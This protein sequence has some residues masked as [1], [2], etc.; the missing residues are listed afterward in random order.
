ME[1]FESMPHEQIYQRAQRIDAAAIL[2]SSFAWL[3]VAAGVSSSAPTAQ[4]G[5]AQVIDEAGWSGAAAD[6]AAASMRVF[7]DSVDDLAAVCAEVG[8]RLGG[9]A[10]AAEAV[11]IAVVPPGDSGPIGTIARILEAAKVIDAQM[12]AEALRQEALLA[13]NMI[14]KPAYGLAGTN[15]PGLPE[16]SV[17]SGA[18]VPDSGAKPT[19]HDA[20]SALADVPKPVEPLGNPGAADLPPSATAPPA[21]GSSVPPDTGGESAPPTAGQPVAPPASGVSPTTGPPVPPQPVPSADPPV[22][23]NPGAPVQ[24]TAPPPAPSSG[25]PV[26]PPAPGPAAPQPPGAGALTDPGGQPGVTG[27]IPDAPKPPAQA[28]TGLDQPGVIGPA[29]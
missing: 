10:A 7:A 8:A 17:G 5:A 18:G 15:V 2:G 9:V 14:Y 22:P 1:H 19:D 23:N 20:P 16:V 29:R 13:M 24:P 26:E 21:P 27:P 6:A 25:E 11:K 12:A 4:K 28:P 3:E